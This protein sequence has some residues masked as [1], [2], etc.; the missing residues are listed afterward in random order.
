MWRWKMAGEDCPGKEMKMTFMKV[1]LNDFSERRFQGTILKGRLF[2]VFMK[3]R[4]NDVFYYFMS[5]DDCLKQLSLAWL[6]FTR[7]KAMA[8]IF[9]PHIY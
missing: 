4:E 9:W 8:S 1:E 3:R 7:F 5:Y 6:G 2:R